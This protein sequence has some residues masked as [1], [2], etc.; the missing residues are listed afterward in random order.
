MG[1]DHHKFPVDLWFSGTVLYFI[2][3]KNDN[4]IRNEADRFFPVNLAKAAL[5]IIWTE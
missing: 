1:A 4:Y 2:F 3:V 5:R